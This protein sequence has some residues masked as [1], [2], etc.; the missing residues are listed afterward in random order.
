MKKI[1]STFTLNRICINFS[2]FDGIC[3]I[4]TCL[5][6]RYY[7]PMILFIIVFIYHWVGYRK[8]KR[9]PVVT[10][11]GKWYINLSSTTPI[12]EED[13]QQIIDNVNKMI[14]E[15]IIRKTVL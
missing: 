6:A 1:I 4:I 15:A 2:I 5:I 11:K 3:L 9:K 7:I 14:D 12:I 8:V 10:E 13:R